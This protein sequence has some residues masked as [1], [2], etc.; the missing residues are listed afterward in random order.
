MKTAES[1]PRKSPFS[2]L[3]ELWRRLT[4]RSPKLPSMP[5][6]E[7]TAL[8]RMEGEGGHT[9]LAPPLAPPPAP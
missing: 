2:F 4:T 7:R 1:R 6:E 5:I 9:P 3:V 8:S